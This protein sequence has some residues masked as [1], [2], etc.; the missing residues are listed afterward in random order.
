M[1]LIVSVCL[2]AV[3]NTFCMMIKSGGNFLFQIT[4]EK[5]LGSFNKRETDRQRDRQGKKGDT[6]KE[7]FLRVCF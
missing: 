2:M 4:V 5:S 6:N 3:A 7:L 1:P